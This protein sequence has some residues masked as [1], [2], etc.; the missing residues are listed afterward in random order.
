MSQ[1]AYQKRVLLDFGDGWVD[2]PA[3]EASLSVSGTVLDDT[4]LGEDMRSR[5]IGLLEWSVSTTVLFDADDEIVTDLQAAFFARDEIDMRYLNDG[6]D[7]F[8]G[9]VVIENFDMSGGVDELETVDVNLLS[10]GALEVYEE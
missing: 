1:A 6:T 8:E 5:L 10:A 4:V 7:G 3:N 9:P 2:L